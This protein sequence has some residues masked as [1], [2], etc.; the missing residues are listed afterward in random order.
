MALSPA[1]VVVEQQQ[2]PN[3][4]SNS[5][6][7]WHIVHYTKGQTVKCTLTS[8]SVSLSPMEEYPPNYTTTKRQ[9]PLLVADWP[10]IQPA[11]K[12][13]GITTVLK[14]VFLITR[15]ATEKASYRDGL[16]CPLNHSYATPIRI[17]RWCFVLGMLLSST[18]TTTTTVQQYSQNVQQYFSVF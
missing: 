13:V 3:N 15:G 6:H 4:A 1:T 7:V 18:T 2:T 16:R 5:S 11:S 17:L 14:I 12:L 8:L 10:A 9:T